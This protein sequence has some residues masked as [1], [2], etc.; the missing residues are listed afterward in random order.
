M[1]SIMLHTEKENRIKKKILIVDD[2]EMNRALLSDM[3]SDEFEILEA[4]NGLEASAIL[5]NQEQ[6]I[7]LMLLDIVMPVMDGFEMLAVMNKNGWIKSIPVIMISAETV[8]SYVDRAYDLGVL[9]YISR[10]FDER[11]VRRRV[12]STIMLAAKQKELAHMVMD[13]IYEK[14]KDNKMMVEILSN[15]VEFRNGESGLHVLHI[16]TL[17][18]LLLKSLLHKTDKYGISRKDIPL[19]CNAAAL[20]DIGK[21]VVPSEILNK[22]GRLTNEEFAIMKTHAAEGANMLRNVTMWENEPLIETGYQIC[23]WHHERYDGRGYPDGLKGEEIP[24]AAQVVAL[25]D[26]YDALTSKRVYK[27]AY[28]HEKTI[29]MI[30]NGECGA[31]NP[32]LLE[33][34]EDISDT[35]KNEFG[36]M[37]D[38]SFSPQKE[39]L[40]SV[41]QIVARDGLDMSE[42]TL[43]LLEHERTKYQ[44]FA[45]LSQ[46][47]QFEYT[48][49]PELLILSEWG[50]RYLELPETIPNPR[51]SSF[52][53]E[54]FSPEDFA[55]LLDA[56]KVTT[57]KS[58]LVDKNFI[59]HIKGHERWSRVIARS[60]WGSEEPPEYAGAIGKIV[61]IH[62]N[63]ERMSHLELIAAHDSLTGLLNHAEAKRRITALLSGE[64]EEKHYIML[65]FDMDHF[66]QANDNYGHLFGDEVLKHV[67]QTIKKCTRSDDIAARYGGDEFM[68]F[69]AYKTTMEPQVK[70]IYD[71]L[72][73]QYKDFPIRI[74]MGIS[75]AMDCDGDYD[76]L[77]HMADEALYA[78]KQTG[79]GRYCFYDESVKNVL[80]TASDTEKSERR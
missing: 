20:H 57:P 53:K 39:I 37:E 40:D 38:T 41:E 61:D 29:E 77:F 52:G 3:L 78:V 71:Q 6:E 12:I 66:K 15:L 11:T 64:E 9:D 74:S 8:P 27:A 55:E 31:F 24:I 5:Q 1:E 23:R 47:I 45:E 16:R 56:L 76:K 25:A 2:A 67:A 75:C 65:L 36:I 18:E 48:A 33:C 73:G 46:E 68:I 80:E 4:E 30:R 28:S 54:I 49:M 62:D 42:R 19:I 34:L 43:H 51:E 72:T 22:P 26:V 79:R 50:A 44:F 10:P 59:L 60:M 58:P 7:S 14:E 35:L 21:I 69:M 32:L 17:T 63:M 70:R 13:Q